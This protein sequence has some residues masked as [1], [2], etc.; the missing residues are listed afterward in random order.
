MTRERRGPVCRKCATEELVDFYCR[1]CRARQSYAHPRTVAP[2]M[3]K[4][5]SALFKVIRAFAGEWADIGGGS[6]DEFLSWLEPSIVTSERFKAV[7]EVSSATYTVG[8]REVGD[9]A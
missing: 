6:V 8:R 5:D 1:N 4:I 2:P 9:A 3:L 7:R